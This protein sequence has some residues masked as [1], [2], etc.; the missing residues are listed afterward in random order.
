[1]SQPEPSPPK[2]AGS[3]QLEISLE[4]R[5]FFGNYKPRLLTIEKVGTRLLMA[6]RY[7]PSRK[8]KN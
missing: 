6:Y 4:K 7:I 2:K 8:V 5:M 1:M 3:F